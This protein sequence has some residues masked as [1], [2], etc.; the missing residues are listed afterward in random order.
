M[1]ENGELGK[2]VWGLRMSGTL[3]RQLQ[4]SLE[5]NTHNYFKFKRK[6]RENLQTVK[7]HHDGKFAGRG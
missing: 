2:A 5:G 1:K 7:I 3:K 6:I 4:Q